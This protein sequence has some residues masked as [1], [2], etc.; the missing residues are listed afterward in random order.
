MR[1]SQPFCWSL[2]ALITHYLMP[3]SCLDSCPLLSYKT[4][5]SSTMAEGLPNDTGFVDPKTNNFPGSLA[6][7]CSDGASIVIGSLMGTSPVTVFVGECLLNTRCQPGH[8]SFPAAV[9]MCLSDLAQLLS[10]AVSASRLDL[11]ICTLLFSNFHQF[12]FPVF[13]WTAQVM[14]QGTDCH[15]ATVCRVSHRYQGGRQD[16]HCGADCSL[17]DVHRPL[18]Y[19]NHW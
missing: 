10:A 19:S 11:A 6:A 9:R 3:Q 2:A 7:Y 13:D 5:S 15:G 14:H 17:L 8:P 1:Y 4:P 18:V 12:Q 16:R